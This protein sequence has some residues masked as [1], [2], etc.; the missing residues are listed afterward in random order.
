MNNSVFHD[1][2]LVS[3]IDGTLTELSKVPQKNLDAIAH[4]QQLGG[5]FTL[6]TGRPNVPWEKFCH[7]F[8]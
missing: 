3:D 5:T 2:L 4:F 8:R 7:R 6:C 1:L